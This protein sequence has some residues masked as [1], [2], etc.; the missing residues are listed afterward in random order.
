[1]V[2]RRRLRLLGRPF[3][4]LWKDNRVLQGLFKALLARRPFTSLIKTTKVVLIRLIKT[5]IVIVLRH[6]NSNSWSRN[7]SL[8]HEQ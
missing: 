5:T 2:L 7:N 8:I 1:M 6:S 4:G 3:K